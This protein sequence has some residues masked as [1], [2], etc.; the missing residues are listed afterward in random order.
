MQAKEKVHKAKMSH[1]DFGWQSDSGEYSDDSYPEF[2][3]HQEMM[4]ATQRAKKEA[5]MSWFD[6]H[7][8]HLTELPAVPTQL[9][10]HIS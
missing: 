9:R 3:W 1:C 4:D 8:Y 6:Y 10:R 5:V 7:K 2:N